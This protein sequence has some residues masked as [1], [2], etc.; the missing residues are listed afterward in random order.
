VEDMQKDYDEY[1]ENFSYFIL[2]KIETWQE[3][4]QEYEW[5]IK[6]R[7]FDRKFGYNYKDN[8][9]EI[10]R[11]SMTPPFVEGLPLITSELQQEL[12]R[13][14]YVERITQLCVDCEDVALLDLIEKLL[15]KKGK[16]G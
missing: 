5:M 15:A 7:S 2:G 10:L 11:K 16:V 14:E 8:E 3:R 9:Q 4:K 13:Q 1:G 6:Y 12:V